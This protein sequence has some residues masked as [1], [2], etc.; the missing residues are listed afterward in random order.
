MLDSLVISISGKDYEDV[1]ESRID[2]WMHNW[3]KP[4]A[5]AKIPQ[6]PINKDNN[7]TNKTDKKDNTESDKQSVNR[8]LD[9]LFKP[10]AIITKMDVQTNHLYNSRKKG[11]I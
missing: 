4:D 7:N 2:Y 3:G 6:A 5:P 1:W 10:Q 11:H 9:N 8:I